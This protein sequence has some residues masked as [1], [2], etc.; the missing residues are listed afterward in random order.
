MRVYTFVTEGGLEKLL[1]DWD[2]LSGN[3]NQKL[4]MLGG[5]TPF[6]GQTRA[7]S[8]TSLGGVGD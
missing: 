1:P 6:F 7:L 4:V 5:K 2:H 8:K 3:I